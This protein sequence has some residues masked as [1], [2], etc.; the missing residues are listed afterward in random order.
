V[1][2]ERARAPIRRRLWEFII[3]LSASLSSIYWGLA[4][5]IRLPL[6]CL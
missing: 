6:A 4:I 2:V 1:A 5:S 3:C